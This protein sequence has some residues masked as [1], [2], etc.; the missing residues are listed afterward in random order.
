MRRK[1]RTPVRLATNDAGSPRPPSRRGRGFR[2]S[3]NL[4]RLLPVSFMPSRRPSSPASYPTPEEILSGKRSPRDPGH[5][6]DRVL[7]IAPLAHRMTV[8]L[9]QD[10]RR[11]KTRLLQHREQRR[12][13]RRH[14]AACQNLPAPI[15]HAKSRL[16][17]RHV[18]SDTLH[19]GHSPWFAY[20]GASPRPRIIGPG[21]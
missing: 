1:S 6:P 3:R 10:P 7:R 16:F 15:L 14:L 9:E 13:V 20:W 18:K 5:A 2:S 17:L 19:Q 12:R 21:E 8:R 11:T 4:C